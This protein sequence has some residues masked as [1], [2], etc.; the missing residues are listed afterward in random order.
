MYVATPI[1]SPQHTRTPTWILQFSTPF[2]ASTYQHRLL[3][4]HANMRA[5]LPRNRTHDLLTPSG[6]GISPATGAIDP[7]TGEDIWKGLYLYALTTVDQELLVTAHLPPFPAIVG[8][9]WGDSR[10]WNSSNA[11][12]A[13]WAV[14][15]SAERGARLSLESIRKFI[16]PGQSPEQFLD[17]AEKGIRWKVVQGPDAVDHLGKNWRKTATGA[18]CDSWL[19]RFQSEKG[20]LHFWRT[21]HRKSL[22]GTEKEGVVLQ[23]D[24]LW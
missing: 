11:E 1:H 7:A 15:V 12:N 14:M 19:V 13:C 20:A 8:K 2:H 10:R 9:A 23:V 3:W 22:P 16:L 24:L 18:E 4:L 17:V 5:C 6:L 21:W